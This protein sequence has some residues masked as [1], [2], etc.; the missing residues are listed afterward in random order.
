MRRA[1]VVAAVLVLGA[2]LAGCAGGADSAAGAAKKPRADIEIAAGE[3]SVSPSDLLVDSASP[4]SVAVRNSL[5]MTVPWTEND[6]SLQVTSLDPYDW[7]DVGRPDAYTPKG[8][9]GKH[10]SPGGETTTVQLTTAYP[11]RGAPFVLQFT[12]PGP[13]VIGSVELQT[14]FDYGLR[15]NSGRYVFAGWGLRNGS[16]RCATDRVVSGAYT[17]VVACQGAYSAPST[18][19]TIEKTPGT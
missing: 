18:L 15:D 2:G 4:R 17:F 5:P 9:Q 11:N 8:L 12:R 3:P 10:L 19:I 13:Q 14:K 16:D 6:V 1:A 7:G